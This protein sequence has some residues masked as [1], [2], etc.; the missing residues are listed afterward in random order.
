[1][2]HPVHVAQIFC[3]NCAKRK[4][5]S[6][7]KQWWEKIEKNVT[8]EIFLKNSRVQLLRIGR[9]IQ[10]KWIVKREENGKKRIELERR[11][12]PT[13]ELTSESLSGSNQTFEQA[14]RKGHYPFGA[15]AKLIDNGSL[16]HVRQRQTSTRESNRNEI[17]IN[18]RMAHTY[19]RGKSR[20]LV[21]VR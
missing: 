5:P 10:L 9:K 11:V 3:S 14:S 17:R 6:R 20:H 7:K 19:T 21:P 2:R 13:K 12:F 1:M 15:F 8:Y 16:N 4:K 18:F